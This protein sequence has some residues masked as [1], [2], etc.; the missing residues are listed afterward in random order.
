LRRLAFLLFLSACG[1][2]SPADT[3]A[4]ENIPDPA[5]EALAA[6][7]L[8]AGVAAE[9]P[10]HLQARVER[11]M[12][13]ILRDAPGARYANVRPG[14]AGSAC[15]EV[16]SKQDNG[17]YGGLRPFVVTPEGIAIVSP[18]ASIGFGDSA[19]IFPDYYMRWCAST[20]EL[21]RLGPG[22]GRP[23]PAP[24][25]PDVQAEIPDTPILDPS[26]PGAVPGPAERPKAAPP[27]PPRDSGADKDDSFFNAVVR[28]D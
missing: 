24:P 28:A 27:R 12:A 11:A 22:G 9:D 10:A 8:A 13:I 7:N 20:E 21:T 23:L 6:A 18:T 3:S 26:L 19:D 15:G 14:I 17:K 25:G 5:A 1:S 16:D 2:Q 4:D